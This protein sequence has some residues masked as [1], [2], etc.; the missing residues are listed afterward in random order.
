MFTDDKRRSERFDLFDISRIARQLSNKVDEAVGQ[1]RE[2][3]IAEL[4]TIGH[5]ARQIHHWESEKRNRTK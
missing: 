2:L 3:T 5:Y 1:N 4:R